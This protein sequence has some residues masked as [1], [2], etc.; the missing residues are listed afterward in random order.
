MMVVRRCFNICLD[1]DIS[2]VNLREIPKTAALLDQILEGMSSE[3]AWWFDTLKSGILP[4]GMAEADS[5]P[6]RKLF[7][8]YIKHAQQQGA[9]RRAI[10][11]K[12]GM[13]LGK[14][15]GSELIRYR[16]DYAIRDRQGS[17]LTERGRVYKFPPLKVCRE[18]FAQEMGQD[19]PWGSPDDEWQHEQEFQEFQ[20]F[21]DDDGLLM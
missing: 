21:I 2:I 16:A 17:K 8:R 3:Q 7:M 4:W 14:H 18:K 20:E 19:I 11:T 12:I 9:R 10:E 15:L 6:A 1:F 13:F 5:C